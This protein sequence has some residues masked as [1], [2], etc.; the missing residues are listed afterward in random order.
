MSPSNELSTFGLFSVG[1]PFGSSSAVFMEV[2]GR[3]QESM[4]CFSI[5]FTV[6]FG[7]KGAARIL[8]EIRGI[9]FC[10]CLGHSCLCKK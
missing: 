6:R 9:G 7:L 1:N 5:M 8:G 10:Y 2:R 3:L 4:L